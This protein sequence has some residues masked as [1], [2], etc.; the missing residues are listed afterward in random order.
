M[1]IKNIGMVLL[2]AFILASCTPITPEAR[3][4]KYMRMYH[5]SFSGIIF[6]AQKGKVL[7]SQGYGLA[8]RELDVFPLRRRP[9]LGLVQ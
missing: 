1:K 2:V 9:N 4:E 8:D 5:E 6:V 7:T 3:I